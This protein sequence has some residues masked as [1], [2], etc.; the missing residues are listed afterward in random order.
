MPSMV[1]RLLFVL[2]IVNTAIYGALMREHGGTA[3]LGRVV[4]GH[5]FVGRLRTLTE[6]SPAFYDYSLWHG[7]FSLALSV[8]V[9]P[10]WLLWRYRRI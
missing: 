6:V 3:L 7:W 1:F 9:L 8:V 10:L 4:D 5:Y 2:W